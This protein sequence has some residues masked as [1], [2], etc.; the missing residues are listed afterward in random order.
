M[1]QVLSALSNPVRLQ[2]IRCLSQKPK[3]VTE[4]IAI[5]GLSQSAVSQHL[6]KLR[7][8]GLVVTEKKGKTVYYALAYPQL[9]EL[10]VRLQAFIREVEA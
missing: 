10:C 1:S 8:A 6:S 3:S 2:T 4:M 5:C 7:G 9:P